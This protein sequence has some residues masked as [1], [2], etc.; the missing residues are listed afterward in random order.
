[1]PNGSKYTQKILEQ[2]AEYI[3]EN[4]KSATSCAEEMGNDA[5]ICARLLF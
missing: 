4:H 1:M 2:K 5:N 3:L